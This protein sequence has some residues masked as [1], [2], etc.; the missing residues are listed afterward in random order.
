MNTRTYK[1]R[2]RAGVAP[3]RMQIPSREAVPDFL[4]PIFAAV[5]T[6]TSI[7]AVL[8]TI[9]RE[10]GFTSFLY[11]GNIA[12]R[13]RPGIAHG[14]YGWANVPLIWTQRYADHEYIEVD[15]RVTRTWNS[16]LP[17]VW[18]QQSERGVSAVIDAFLDDALA[19]GI[20][21]GIVVAFP[22][23]L[24]ARA[25]F[26]LNVP[27]AIVAAERQREWQ[28]KMGDIYLFG[29]IIH[30]LWVAT[31]V[32]NPQ[33]RPAPGQAVS[34]REAR[35]LLQV[36]GGASEREV[37]AEMGLSRAEVGRRLRGVCCKLGAS[38]IEEAVRIA[39]GEA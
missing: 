35:L 6:G 26:S 15:P 28:E 38:T 9:A 12:N 21:S 32:E 19:H 39:L 4:Q 8:G 10:L 20:G 36:A 29:V 13:G 25:S 5:E 17:Q 16:E 2:L 3:A 18:D 7:E 22:A 24:G 23:P 14:F 1:E 33:G 34:Q 30:A 37:A 11:K 27:E 31:V